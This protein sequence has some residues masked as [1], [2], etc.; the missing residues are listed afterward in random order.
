MAANDGPVP[1]RTLAHAARLTR[2]AR[3]LPSYG[4]AAAEPT[5]DYVRRPARVDEVTEDVR[6][7]SLLRDDLAAAGVAV[8]E[9]AGPARLVDPHKVQSADGTRL[10]ADKIIL[11][12]GEHHVRCR[13]R[14]PI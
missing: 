8:Y 13:F 14:A 6:A 5:L 12:T 11:C 9:D 7:H 1:A 4:I 10:R 2:E 3:Q